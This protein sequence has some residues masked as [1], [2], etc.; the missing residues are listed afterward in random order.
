MELSSDEK[1]ALE[2]DH[3]VKI[4]KEAGKALSFEDASKIYIEKFKSV[5]K[6]W[7]EEFMNFGAF[8]KYSA[9]SDVESVSLCSSVASK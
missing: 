6:Q 9:G 4:V 2:R 8:L 1:C 7:K 3:V 5:L